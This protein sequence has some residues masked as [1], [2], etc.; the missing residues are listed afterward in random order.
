MLADVYREGADHG[1][2]LR[3]IDESIE[4]YGR[5]GA[6]AASS[7]AY[8]K[9]GR[10]LLAEARWQDALQAF[11]QSHAASEAGAD[12][13]GAAFAKMQLCV[14][15]R[16]LG[17]YTDAGRDCEAALK[18]FAAA[19]DGM[20]ERETQQHF[21]ALELAM[22]RA[23]R[24]L[25]RLAEAGESDPAKL[26]IEA[27]LVRARARAATEQWP[28]A[29]SDYEL[30]T[31]AT[32]DRVRAA[33]QHRAAVLR[34]RSAAADTLC[35]AVVDLDHFKRIN[36]R[37]GHRAGDEVLRQFAF[38]ARRV[39]RPVDIVARYGGEEFLVLL[40]HTT[41]EQAQVVV[42]RL[43][44]AAKNVHTADGDTLSISAG[45]AAVAL[46]ENSLDQAIERADAALYDAKQSGRDRIRIAA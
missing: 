13:L 25:Q 20:M 1:E 15:R 39:L 26:P 27:I 7:I 40:P 38:E 9:R 31:Q 35:I 5:Q 4:F 19:G 36:D 16:E 21:A 45:L 41:L 8:Y 12:E 34:E 43:R 2:A 6:H 30:Y 29:M 46:D 44:R 23:R 18:R 28:A 11:Q 24:A 32:R 3:L 42:E 37:L 17:A 22:G 33:E 14:V 10:L